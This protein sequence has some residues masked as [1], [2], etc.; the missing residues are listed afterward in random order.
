MFPR[1][2]LAHSS[3]DKGYVEDVISRLSRAQVVYDQ[4]VF[5]PGQDFR[6]LIREGIEKAS[7]LVLFATPASLT[8]SWVKFELDEYELK[9]IGDPS[10]KILV[11]GIDASVKSADLPAWMRRCLALLGGP[12]AVNAARMIQ[13]RLAEQVASEYQPPFVGREKEIEEFKKDLFPRAGDKPPQ[14]LVVS[15]LP[16]IGRRTFVG[17]V[18]RDYLSLRGAPSVN[19]REY[20]TIDSVYLRLLDETGQIESRA[21]FAEYREKFIGMDIGEQASEFIRVLRVCASNNEAPIFLDDYGRFMDEHGK[22]IGQVRMI[23]E[24]LVEYPNVFWGVVHRRQPPAS[25]LQRASA[26]V[27]ASYSL[28]PL[29]LDSTRILLAQHF[30]MAELDAEPAQMDRLAVLIGGYPPLAALA[31]KLARTYGL[32]TLLAD[33]SLLVDFKIRTF[34]PLLSKLLLSDEHWALLRLLSAEVA[35]PFDV[36]GIALGY[37]NEQCAH[38]LR[39]LIEFNLVVPTADQYELSTPLREAV[40]RMKGPF[41]REE[42]AALAQ[43]LRTKYWSDPNSM[44]PL[45]VVGAIIHAIAKSDQ[46][47]LEDFRD[48]V[49]PSSLLRVASE[50]YHEQ[51]WDTAESFAKRA[52]LANPELHDAR[53][54][55]IKS[56]VKQGKWG[57]AERE[58]SEVEQRGLRRQF[59]LKGFIQWKRGKLLEAIQALRSALSVGDRSISVTR[60]LAHC[61]FRLGDKRSLDEAR[62]LVNRALDRPNPN[63]FVVDLAVQIAIER[64]SWGEIEELLKLLATIDSEQSFRHRQATYR[65]KR[66]RLVEALEDAQFACATPKPRFEMRA[67][68]ADILIESRKFAEAVEVIDKLPA[69]VDWQADIQVGLRCKCLLRQAKWREAEAVWNQLTR[70]TL[71]VHQALRRE[72]LKQKVADSL[73]SPVEREKAEEALAELS[74]DLPL[75]LGLDSDGED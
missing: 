32:S 25:G 41:S 3:V 43:K 49:L 50:A 70:K 45:P 44:P 40:S 29:D 67:Q 10:A 37:E 7:L 53:E 47:Q 73:L 71:P 30:R 9:R 17:R 48:V 74:G 66:G 14:T 61:L 13:Q 36:I 55:L 75:V 34:V 31:A 58:L 8:S 22:Y 20:D 26:P 33:E 72:V 27:A 16:G 24:G 11:I 19:V 69:R 35:L 62:N 4:A 46:R 5:E 21:G 1:A 52:L 15:G 12:A 6:P 39:E 57:D 64:Q 60:D 18:V 54:V 63:R 38:L 28:R 56:F 42:F 59:Y 2:Y 65:A 68:L 23:M 51:D